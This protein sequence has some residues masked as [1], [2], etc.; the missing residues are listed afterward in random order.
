[1]TSEKLVE[2][3]GT[4]VSMG[5]EVLAQDCCRGFYPLSII[6]FK[7]S[8]KEATL[9]VPGQS[10]LRIT[11][12]GSIRV[13]D[14]QKLNL[15]RRLEISGGTSDV[16]LPPVCKSVEP[17]SAQHCA[18]KRIEREGTKKKGKNISENF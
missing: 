8:I 4:K 17:A 12:S 18:I 11:Q 5:Q 7:G 2:D 10:E 13:L 15:E 1:M 3:I 14:S 9:Y 6:A 16:I